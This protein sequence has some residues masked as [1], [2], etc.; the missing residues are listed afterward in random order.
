M[1]QRS[2]ITGLSGL[3]VTT[4]ETAFLR[5]ACPAGIILF[6]R[7][8]ETPE[9]VRRLIADARAAIGAE[10][11]VLVDQE[12]GRVQRLRPP[13]WRALPSGAMYA[14]RAV[15]N[16]Q[17][18]G[19][20][21]RTI[22]RLV[23]HDLRGV[24]ITCN[25]TPVLDVPVAGAHDV[26]GSRALGAT[27]D[28]IIALGRAIAEGHIAGGVLPVMKHMP[29]HG[30]ATVDTHHA[31]PTVTTSE[32]ELTLSDF[33]PFKALADLPAG[34]T[35]H[36]VFAAIDPAAPAST[37]AI[38]THRIIRGTIGFDGLLMSDDLSMQALSGTL[39]TRAA[40]ALA[41]GT[42]LALHC[43]GVMAEMEQ[44][45]GVAP[46]LAGLAA[47][48]FQRALAVTSAVAAFDLV[49]AAA[50]LARVLGAEAVA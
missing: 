47:A 24:G 21:A 20:E 18:A 16:L 10:A 17:A 29:G 27:P 13:H 28:T 37:S 30:R 11:L 23:A 32:A 38:V 41:A 42:D 50:C 12:G 39:G 8:I 9:Q 15:D 40:A 4:E 43:N 3:A 36:V 7:N 35:A 26:I 49:A 5:Q 45:A 19:I 48:R 6:A 34:M 1:T 46:V 31:L 33:V 14:A 44:V 2:F 22:A 25:C